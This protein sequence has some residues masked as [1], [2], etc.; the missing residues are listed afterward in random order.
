MTNTSEPHSDDMGIHAK[1]PT[2]FDWMVQG[3][4]GLRHTME[5][6]DSVEKDAPFGSFFVFAQLPDLPWLS[7][8]SSA[9]R[10]EAQQQ[11]TFVAQALMAAADVLEQNNDVWSVA[12]ERSLY[13]SFAVT[14]PLDA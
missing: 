6:V 14:F 4:V 5:M 1:K 13:A 9:F 12:V 11:E 2:N 10:L 3:V 8:S 7:V